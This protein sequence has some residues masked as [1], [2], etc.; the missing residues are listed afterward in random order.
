MALLQ[1][2]LTTVSKM[3]S[4]TLLLSIIG[5]FPVC[6]AL[7]RLFLHPL[8]HIPGPWFACI[9]SAFLHII[10]YQGTESRVFAHY[11]RK[12]KSP[13]LR[14]APNSVSVSD[15]AALHT[16]YVAGGGLPK[17][18][19][20]RNFRI[21]GHETIFSSINP[22]FRDLRAKA[23]LPLFAPS[24]IR[25]SGEN[26]GAIQ[27]SVEKFVALLEKEKQ[28]ACQGRGNHHRV[29]ILDLTSKLSIDILTGYLFDKVYG[30]LNEH[31]NNNKMNIGSS[32]PKH[33][34]LSATPFVLAIVAFS[35]FSLL[36]NWIFTIVFSIW[37]RV[38]MRETDLVVSLGKVESFMN[39][40]MAETET[41][42]GRP[43]VSMEETRSQCKGVMF[44]GADS[45]ALVQSTILFHL[46]QQ[47]A[48]LTRLKAEVEGTT[49]ST[50]LQ[51]LPYLRAV[52]R[53]GLR[54]ALTN[55][56]RMT[57]IVTTPDAKGINV[58]GFHLPPGTIVGAAPYIFHLNEEVFPDPLKFQPERWLEE[59]RDGPGESQLRALRDRDTFP[60]GLGGRIC[61]G[62]NLATYQV[63]STTKAIVQSGVLE[64]A[65][66]C[67]ERIEMIGWFN[68][69][70][71]EHHL[72]IEWNS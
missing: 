49:P 28:E 35:R 13:V 60:F 55:P 59:K 9:S 15:G 37:F 21:E 50:E 29:D 70:I 33:K 64:G 57:R 6:L 14:I 54:L 61:L 4:W 2:L 18:S 47:P 22:A 36:P 53:E 24:R 3:S 42:L 51:S 69:E 12:Y 11:H 23:V 40:L 16:I 5:L 19:R 7:Y 63:L 45:T 43:G 68:A 27:Q 30:G 8:S 48:V 58:S 62:R 66:T 71:K 41:Q 39:E 25:T 31:D 44:A 26:N 34:R 17:D 56:T 38:A 32:V 1:N 20:Y 46:I 67:Q 52:F 72:E 65:R 10:C